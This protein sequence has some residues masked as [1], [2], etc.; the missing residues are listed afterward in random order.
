MTLLERPANIVDIAMDADEYEKIRKL[1]GVT[2]AEMARLLGVDYRTVTRWCAGVM[3]F[4]VTTARFLRV[5]A[6]A[7]I[8]GAQAAAWVEVWLERLKRQRARRQAKATKAEAAPALRRN[9]SS[10]KVA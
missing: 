8:S 6:A 1:L 7:E 2:Q 3:P 10:K 5:L 9:R 4:P